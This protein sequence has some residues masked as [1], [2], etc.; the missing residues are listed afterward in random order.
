MSPCALA[1]SQSLDDAIVAGRNQCGDHRRL[2]I[3]NL[4]QHDA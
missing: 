3:L 2:V 4:H 1:T